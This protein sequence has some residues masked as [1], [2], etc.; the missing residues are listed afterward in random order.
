MLSI[1][2]SE[3]KR[4]RSQLCVCYRSYPGQGH[5]GDFG[6]WVSLV[7]D[8]LGQTKHSALYTDLIDSDFQRS[9]TSPMRS[10]E[11]IHFTQE[12]STLFP[13]SKG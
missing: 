3:L 7:R 5:G 13:I 10:N 2:S 9:K 11:A 12:D 1:L 4:F 6:C 8:T